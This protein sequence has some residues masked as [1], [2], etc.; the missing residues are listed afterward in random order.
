MI[1]LKFTIS[2]YFKFLNL[3]QKNQ[4]YWE[5]ETANLGG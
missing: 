5:I 1:V 2:V 4:S 3:L